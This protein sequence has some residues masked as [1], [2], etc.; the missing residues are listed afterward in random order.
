MSSRWL[1]GAV[2][3]A[4]LVAVSPV[5]A[6]QLLAFPYLAA[7]GQHRI[8]SE[9]PIDPA[10]TKLVTSAD[11]IVAH[12]PLGSSRPSNQSIF[13]TDGGWRWTWLAL[14]SRGAFALS[15]PVTETIIVNRASATRDVV[16][17]GGSIAGRRS[18]HGTLAHEMAHGLIRARFGVTADARYP[19]EL[20]EGYCDHVA[21]GGSLTDAQAQ[22]LIAA[23]REVPALIYWR[24][25]KKVEAAL[26][27][28]HGDVD[29]LFA[30]WPS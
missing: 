10:L 28:N 4:A 6:P 23:H 11:T 18:L 21:G 7:V 3:V 8:Y 5:A 2:V 9:K 1:N 29:A 17:N 19:A 27:A 16:E 13:L 14:Q 24:G 26:A 22:A 20:R 30:D 15:R 12:S 25:R